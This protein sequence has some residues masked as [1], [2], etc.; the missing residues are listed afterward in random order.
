MRKLYEIVLVLA[1]AGLAA[2]MALIEIPTHSADLGTVVG[3]D[4]LLGAPP[5]ISDSGVPP[6]PPLLFPPGSSTPVSIEPLATPVPSLTLGVQA[7]ASAMDSLGAFSAQRAPTSLNTKAPAMLKKSRQSPAAKSK[8]APTLGEAKQRPAAKAKPPPHTSKKIKPPI[9][10]KS[11]H[12]STTAAPPAAK[13]K[14]SDTSK[15]SKGKLKT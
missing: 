11:S 4:S 3:G 13:A 6:L 7:S 10:P 1:A 14:G 8:A 9:K 2:T 12:T 15:K 5:P